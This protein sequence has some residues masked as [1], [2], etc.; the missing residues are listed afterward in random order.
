MP[1][2]DQDKL[3]LAH[4]VVLD[5]SEWS[6]ECENL[7]VQMSWSGITFFENNTTFSGENVTY[8]NR[9]TLIDNY[10]TIDQQF[11]FTPEAT[12]IATYCQSQM[13]GQN[14]GDKPTC[15]WT[16][17]DVNGNPE[18]SYNCERWHIKSYSIGPLDMKNGSGPMEQHV[19][20]RP[21]KVV[22]A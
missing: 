1:K 3:E 5:L 10:G 20:L 2:L 12:N 22:L 4:K 16:F 14:S 17:H 7:L 18:S 9:R 6:F 8:Q 15:S 11:Y 19:R 13:D 21:E